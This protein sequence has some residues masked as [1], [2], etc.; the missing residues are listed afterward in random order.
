MDP[1]WNCP[2]CGRNF[3]RKGQRHACGVGSRAALLRGKPPA[4]VSLYQSLEADLNRLGPI[5]IVTRDRYA[6]FRTTRIFADLVFMRD[7]L[8]LAIHL[9][10][11]VHEPCFFKIGRGGPN[12]VTHVALL[13]APADL[14]S[15]ARYLEE[16]YRLAVSEET[17]RPQVS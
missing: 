17:A 6:L 13:R 14:G 1:L 7:G 8:R 9:G 10:R 3:R 12:Q 4:L 11:E 15:V 5:E 2:K 16:A